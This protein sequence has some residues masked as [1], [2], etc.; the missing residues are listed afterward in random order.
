[1]KGGI[2]RRAHDTIALFS[3]VYRGSEAAVM[4]EAS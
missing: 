4:M 2:V 1:M 3:L